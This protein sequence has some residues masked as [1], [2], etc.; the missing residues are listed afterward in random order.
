MGEVA[1]QTLPNMEV[2]SY[3]I[4]KPILRPLI[5]LDK[6]EI[7]DLARRI[8]TFGISTRSEVSC[9]YLPTHPITRASVE[10]LLEVARRFGG[11]TSLA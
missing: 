3:G 4:S 6:A 2:V 7:V 5:G 8:G 1:S 10:G 11:E 9:A